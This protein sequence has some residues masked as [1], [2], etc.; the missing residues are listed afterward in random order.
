[1][2]NVKVYFIINDITFESQ[3][4][5]ANNVDIGINVAEAARTDWI[6]YVGPY[7]WNYAY[8]TGGGNPPRIPRLYGGITVSAR[9]RSTILYITDIES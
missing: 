6:A 7:R 3:F 9:S 2:K 4:V 5:D 8:H 1:V